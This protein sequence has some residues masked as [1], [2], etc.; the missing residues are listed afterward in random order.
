MKI[1]VGLA[2]L[3][4]SITISTQAAPT[5]DG[6]ISGAEGWT[7]FRENPDAGP[8][9]GGST[10]GSDD[11]NETSQYHWWDGI[12]MQDRFFNSSPRGGLNNIYWAVD[13]QHLYLAVLG[14]TAPFNAWN[15][16]GTGGNGDQGNLYI[17]IETDGSGTQ[18]N[19]NSAHTSYLRKAVDFLGWQPDYIVGLQFVD[20]GGGANGAANVEK[21]VTHNI[22]GGN[23]QLSKGGNS[24]PF[25]WDAQIISGFGHYEFAIEWSA[26]GF[27]GLPFGT[28][29]KIAAYMTQS[30][31]NWDAYDTA[32]GIG[33]RTTG[34][35]QPFE[36][37]GDHPGDYDTL[38]RLDAGDAAADPH[39]PDGSYPGSNYV[40]PGFQNS[41]VNNDYNLVGR[42]D[43]IDTI[44]GYFKLV[45]V[46]EPTTALLTALGLTAFAWLRRD[47]RA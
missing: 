11:T 34:G 42:Q 33:N 43:E 29:L 19:A 41:E 7:L 12:A 39:V 6:A 17:A 5:I 3:L 25:R 36:Q 40:V 2:I 46:P 24:G 35:S 18:L 20:N 22:T 21:T 27:S 47:K 38:D 44:E 37:I 16:S 1:S 8:F 28:E 4:G 32:P 30:G 10:T 13:S 15:E 45:V 31:E 23:P 26:L 14:G 9:L